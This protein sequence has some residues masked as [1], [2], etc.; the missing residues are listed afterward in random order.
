M[1]DVA[2]PVEFSLS[3]SPSSRVADAW[4]RLIRKHRTV[5]GGGCVR[6]YGRLGHL[7]R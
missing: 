5:N 3:S 1:I 4:C 6:R 2:A 7:D